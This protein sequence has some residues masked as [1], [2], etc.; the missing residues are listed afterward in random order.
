MEFEAASRLSLVGAVRHWAGVPSDVDIMNSGLVALQR[1]P[2]FR[3]IGASSLVT[4][5][6]CY[7]D[8]MDVALV[9]P[10]VAP[11]LRPVLTV[12]G[13][14]AVV[15]GH[16]YAVSVEFAG[17]NDVQPLDSLGGERAAWYV[18]VPPNRLDRLNRLLTL[19]RRKK[20]L[21]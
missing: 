14:E 4:V 18:A 19:R 13:D 6:P 2:D 8:V 5:V 15:P 3:F 9:P 20:A 21:R 17:V 1:V 12:P 16:R 10:K 7:A 11:A